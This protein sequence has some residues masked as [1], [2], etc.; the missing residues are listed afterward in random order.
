[1]KLK[2]T[3]LLVFSIF[4][5]LSLGQEAKSPFDTT[6]LCWQSG[7]LAISLKASNPDSYWDRKSERSCN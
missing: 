4:V 7:R 3:A 6:H 2:L 5:K 1:M